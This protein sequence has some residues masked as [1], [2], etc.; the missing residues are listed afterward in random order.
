MFNIINRVCAAMVQRFGDKGT[1][2]GLKT[3]A[4]KRVCALE[5]IW[6]SVRGDLYLLWN[7]RERGTQIIC[8]QVFSIHKE[9]DW[10]GDV[11][12]PVRWYSLASP[13]M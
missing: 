12:F 5:R 3:V 2:G 9:D 4:Y 8:R 10:D 6:G 7:D 13:A 11:L 1:P